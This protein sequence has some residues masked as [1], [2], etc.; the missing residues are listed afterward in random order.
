MAYK[1]QILDVPDGGTGA[2]TLTGVV[3]GNGTSAMTAS[4]ITQHDVLIGGASNAITS[5]APSATSGVA[6]VSAGASTNPVFGTVVV[7]GGGTG[8][9]TLTGVVT[10]NG[11]S[12]MTASTI[13]QYDMLVGGASNAISSVAPSST[14]GVPLISQG[15]S[16]NPTFGT[17]VVA[18]GGTGAT[19]LT[20]V[21][22]GNGTS[23][24]TASAITQHDVLVGGS[25]NAIT[26]V[27]PSATSGVA[28]VSAGASTNPAFGTVVVAGGGTGAT[29]L[30]N[31]GILV[32]AGTSSITQLTAGSAGQVLQSS[33]SSADPSYSTPTYPSASGTSRTIL[34]SDG[35]NNVYST[36]TWAVPGTS[37]NVLTSDGTNW[38]SA[39]VF[40][41]TQY[42][43]LTGGAGNTINNIAAAAS[44]EV[45]ISNGT[46]AQPSWSASPQLTSVTFDGSNF[47]G[48]YINNG[49]WTPTLTGSSTAGTTTYSIQ[50]GYYMQVG[51][52]V[53]AM[54]TITITAATGTGNATIGGFPV[55]VKSQA[56]GDATGSIQISS[57]VFTWPTNTTTVSFIMT[58]GGT[59]GVINASGSG[60]IASA[61][62]MANGAA[63]F[64][65]SICYVGA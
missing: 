34:V 59:T 38:T 26:S 5:I 12:A 50:H 45:F 55:T 24:M 39:A 16:S 29:T 53:M 37:G 56:S 44:G 58:N 48:I 10:G 18:G 6:L 9:T 62:Q 2:T 17:V 3:T 4:A 27:A 46:S 51:K 15:S 7:A 60:V 1:P 22:T 13:T 41:T 8:A 54:G 30:T 28:L 57:T 65:F 11:T 19:T 36:E 49:T 35:T 40:S 21:V 20:G 32:G 33:G 63:T 42:A 61:I 25:S 43:T 47:L 52:L 14:S 64:K 31:H 23:A